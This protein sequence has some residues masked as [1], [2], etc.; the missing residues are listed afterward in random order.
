MA[1]WRDQRVPAFQDYLRGVLGRE[2]TE[3]DYAAAIMQLE[4]RG[5]GSIAVGHAFRNRLQVEGGDPSRHLRHYD[6]VALGHRWSEVTPKSVAKWG[7]AYDKITAGEGPLRS[8]QTHFFSPDGMQA[9][10]DKNPSLVRSAVRM[11]VPG[12]GSVLV[13]SWATKAVAAGDFTNV[14][15][16]WFLAPNERYGGSGI[17]PRTQVASAASSG[18]PFVASA[19]PATSPLQATPETTPAISS[20]ASAPSPEPSSGIGMPSIKSI[21][22]GLGSVA[23]LMRPQSSQSTE[24]HFDPMPGSPHLGASPVGGLK[25]AEA[26]MPYQSALQIARAMGGGIPGE[27]M[28][29]TGM[30]VPESPEALQAQQR[31]VA[32]GRKPAVMFPRGTPELPLVAGLERVVTDRGVFHFDP[33]QVTAE[34]IVQASREGRENEVLGLGPL[35]KGDVAS[36]SMMSGEP[37]VA[38]TQRDPMGREVRASMATPSTVGIQADT[39]LRSAPPDHD[40]DVEPI[41]GVLEQRGVAERAIGLARAGGGPVEDPGMTSD[42]FDRRPDWRP[43]EARAYEPTWRDRAARALLGALGSDDKIVPEAH[44]RLVG[45]LTGSGSGIGRSYLSLPDVTPGVGM[46]TA[47]ADV[48]KKASVGNYLGAAADGVLATLPWAI[49]RYGGRFLRNTRGRANAIDDG[50]EYWSR[51]VGKGHTVS[52][53]A[54]PGGP[55]AW[56]NSMYQSGGINPVFKAKIADEIAK[57]KAA[58]LSRSA[59]ERSLPYDSLRQQAAEIGDSGARATASAVRPGSVPDLSGL[60]IVRE[61]SEVIANRAAGGVE[62]APPPEWYK[63]VRDFHRMTRENST[64]HAD[65]G[66]VQHRASGGIIGPTGGRADK[67]AT[68]LRAGSHVI[69]A[70]IV[71]HMGQGNSLSG[72]KMLEQMFSTGPYGMR[73]R[74]RADGGE[75]DVPVQ[76][77]DGEFVVPPEV[78]EAVGNGDMQAGHEAIDSWI[79]GMRQE[80][81]DTLMSLPPP[82]KD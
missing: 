67:I 81:I 65:G 69:P 45:G 55:S 11:D 19:A 60:Q 26:A 10:Y 13:P 49:G 71:S 50:A 44:R 58:A 77:S 24:L 1:G 36:E 37:P 52:R 21:A 23:E 41:D 12:H 33:L 2:P 40:I 80:A 16:E 9:Y 17:A 59:A 54:T 66:R 32:A 39:M 31:E 51:D 18:Q 62:M 74:R 5:D 46:A 73:T 30:N 7:E 48:A 29:D 47:G 27:P 3:R 63:G 68:Y 61:P 28:S 72:L 6:P 8:G 38:I 82:A 76:V 79:M 56:T 4:Q 25:L 15:G 64:M 78:V 43:E 22:G 75:V 34:D 20:V 42:D 14:N 35:S 53:E 70:D 57:D